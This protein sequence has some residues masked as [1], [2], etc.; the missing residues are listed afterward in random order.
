MTHVLISMSQLMGTERL[1][2]AGRQNITSSGTRP[3]LVLPFNTFRAQ[4]N[5]LFQHF[6]YNCIWNHGSVHISVSACSNIQLKLC[7]ALI[8]S[9]Q[10]QHAVFIMAEI[11]QMSS[12]VFQKLWAS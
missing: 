11:F 9:I 5:H 1:M 6:F 3:N 2:A 10:P 7:S 4:T 12:C 8:L